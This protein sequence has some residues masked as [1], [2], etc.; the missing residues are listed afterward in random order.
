MPVLEAPFWETKTLEQL[1]TQEWEAL[2]DTCGR[3]CLFKL[4]DEDTHEIFYTRVICR[5]FNI[6]AGACRVYC[7][8]TQLVRTC[9]QL[10]PHRV[11]ELGWIPRTCA[12]RRLAEGR[13]LAAWHPLIAG[14]RKRMQKCGIAVNQHVI[15][16]EMVDMDHLEDYIEEGKK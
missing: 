12:Y 15:S 16:E 4:E 9:L 10:D 14:S 7:D 1:T 3:C 11:S 2:C 13:R 5:Y 8:R 6:E